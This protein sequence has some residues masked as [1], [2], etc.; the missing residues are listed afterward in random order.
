MDTN[1]HILGIDPG[2]DQSAFTFWN[3]GNERIDQ[4]G[5]LD[6]NDILIL[7]RETGEYP[8]SKLI[9]AIEDIECFGMPVGREVFETVRWTGRF[10]EVCA[11][12]ELQ[13]SFI[14]RSKIKNHLCHSSRAKDPNVRAA[15]IERFGPPGVKNKP[16][17]LYGIKT[18][19]WSALSVAVTYGDYLK[20]PLGRKT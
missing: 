17:L 3:P 9:V 18:H 6:N 8:P 4:K 19:I 11:Y 12:Y 15:L 16:G 2:T 14:K 20:D 13:C 1:L 10:Q 7:L 5:I